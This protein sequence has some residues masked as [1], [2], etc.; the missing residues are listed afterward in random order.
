[1]GGRTGPSVRRSRRRL[2]R[3]PF[4]DELVDLLAHRA[5]D[6]GL[7]H[8]ADDLATL[9]D[10][11]DAAAAGDADIRRARLAGTVHFTSHRRDL[12]LLVEAAEFVLH[13]LGELHEIHVG[14][15]ARRARH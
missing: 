5:P 1:R 12:D 11:P 15:A 14:A 3:L 9:E 10:E 13:F 2:R 7:R 4:G 6:L 8:F